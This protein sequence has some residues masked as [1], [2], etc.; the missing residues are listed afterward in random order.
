MIPLEG[1]GMYRQFLTDAKIVNPNLRIVGFTATPFRLKS[2]PICAPDGFLN[3]VCHEVGVRELIVQGYLC[4]LITKA[5]I[6]KADFGQL[7]IRAGEF[8]ADEMEGLMDQETLVR[9]ACAEIV[10]RTVSRN[11]CL[12][13]ASG[14]RHGQHIIDM[15]ER[16]HGIE[17]GF[18]CGETPTAERMP[19]WDGSRPAS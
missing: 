16:E 15:L 6:S 18:V 8:V 4:P 9:S 13:F 5:R 1:E 17:C 3:H 12:I 2:G 10:E 11:A 14:V 19:R 7:H